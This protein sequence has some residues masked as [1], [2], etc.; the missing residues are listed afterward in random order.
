MD[1]VRYVRFSVE[2]HILP[3]VSAHDVSRLRAAIE[4][5]VKGLHPRPVYTYDVMV[6]VE[7]RVSR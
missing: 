5:A 6:N 3:A 1:N 7:D 2:F 4:E